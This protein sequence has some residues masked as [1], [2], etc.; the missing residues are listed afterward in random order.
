MIR[1]IAGDIAKITVNAIVNTANLSWRGGRRVDG[2]VQRAGGQAILR[3]CQK[4]S[5][6]QGGF[7]PGEAVIKTAGL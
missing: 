6:S 7:H 3:K 4:I 5:E 2:A 1:I